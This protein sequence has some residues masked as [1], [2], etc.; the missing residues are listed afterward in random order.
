LNNINELA[1]RKYA[2]EIIKQDANKLTF[3][4]EI[5]RLIALR[6]EVEFESGKEVSI[7]LI[8][9]YYYYYY[10]SYKLLTYLPNTQSSSTNNAT[11]TTKLFSCLIT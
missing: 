9:I 7:Y 8:L 3:I 11:N 5:C 4:N 1:K 6:E 2:I 10:V